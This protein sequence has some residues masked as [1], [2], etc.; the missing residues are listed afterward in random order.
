[1]S[2]PSVLASMDAL[3]ALGKVLEIVAKA[4]TPLSRVA[5]QA[6]GGPRRSPGAGM[7]LGV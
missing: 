1:M 7:S 3:Y 6:A 5:A 2:Y 4:D